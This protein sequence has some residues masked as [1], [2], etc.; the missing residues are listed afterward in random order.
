MEFRDWVAQHSVGNA[1]LD[2]Y[3]HI[4]FQAV[5][6]M[7]RA[8][9]AED[10]PTL[11]NRVQFLLDYGAMHFSTEE[12]LLAKADYPDLEAHREA[13][14]QFKARLTAILEQIDSAPETLDLTQVGDMA[15]TWLRDHILDEDMKF[16]DCLLGKP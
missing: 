9:L 10:L 5:D 14:A 6:E 13:H 3:H 11:K 12:D 7:E 15:R 8:G 2:A 1:L 4:F 16:K